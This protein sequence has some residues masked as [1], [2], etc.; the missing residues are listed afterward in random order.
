MKNDT[1]N[2]KEKYLKLVE[3][4]KKSMLKRKIKIE[5][6][7]DKA[8]QAGIVPPTQKEVD[9]EYERRINRKNN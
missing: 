6:Y 1:I 7:I 8:K 3:S 5:L 4:H 2:Y 9:D